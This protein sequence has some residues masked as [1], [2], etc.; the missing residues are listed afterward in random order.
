MSIGGILGESWGLYTKFFRR[1]FVIALI[2]YL[3]V[4]LLNAL[5]ATVFGHGVG[6]SVLLAVITAV[7]SLVGTFWLQGALVFAVDDVRDGKIDS[8]VGQLFERARP[9]LGALILAGILA[10]LGIAVGLV[11]FIVPGLILLTWWCLIVPVIV[12]E[13]KQVGESFSR[14]RELVRGH[15]WTVFGVVV[16]TAILSAIAS[17]IIQSIFSFLGSFLRYWIGGAIA[18]AVVG[19]FFAIALTLMYFRLRGLGQAAPAAAAE[20]GD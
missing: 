3:I 11:L 14:S 18:G 10:A 8:T 1:F 9:H 17:G 4:D 13:G 6:V 2:V 16:I 20:T 19:P 5:L 15:A 12:L 7:V